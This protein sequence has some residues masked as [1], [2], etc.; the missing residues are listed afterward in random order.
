MV[1][2]PLAEEF[3]GATTTLNTAVNALASITKEIEQRMHQLEAKEAYLKDREKK[4]AIMEK[5][6][7]ERKKEWAALEKEYQA[8]K[9]D[10]EKRIMQREEV[11]RRMQENAAKVK[12]QVYF[13]VGGQRFATTKATLL[14]YK[15]TLLEALITTEHNQRTENGDYFIDHNPRFFGLVLDFLREGKFRSSDLKSIDMEELQEE[16]NFFRI[17]VVLTSRPF[18]GGSLLSEEQKKKILQWLPNKR[19]A[20]LYKAS[21]DG[22]DATDFHHKCD[23]KG[24]TLTLIQV[25]KEG[26]LFGG[27]TSQSWDS[28]NS[29]K[30]DPNAFLFTLTNPHSIPPTKYPIQS[31]MASQAISC[32]ALYCATFGNDV[33]V[34]SASHQNNHSVFGFPSAYVDHTGKGKETFTG[35]DYFSTSEMEVYAVL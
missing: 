4:V 2:N 26:Y 33:R 20:L 14:R 22:F 30:S 8:Q 18:E 35:G 12:Q 5:E 28:T 21:R 3:K 27:F 31:S 16:F 11:D 25:K 1:N 15:G 7:E 13:D 17:P 19:F 24:P 29:A 6:L 9:V 10:S 32:S 34:Y 23:N